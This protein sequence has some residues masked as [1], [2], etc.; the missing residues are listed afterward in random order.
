MLELI[1]VG[2]PGLADVES[3]PW[4]PLVVEWSGTSGETLYWRTGD[5]STSLLEVGVD[6]RTGLPAR[7]AVPLARVAERPDL[8][9]ELPALCA[10]GAP[11]VDPRSWAGARVDEPGEFKLERRRDG[12]SLTWGAAA[13]RGLRS[14]RAVFLL[15]ARDAWCGLLVL[16][17]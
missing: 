17:G 15:D 5:L 10:S 12:W 11:R 4:V 3:D 13:E 6:A 9:V 1:D 7:V 2:T 8:P 14:G 16:D